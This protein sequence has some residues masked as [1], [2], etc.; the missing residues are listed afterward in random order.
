VSRPI[1]LGVVTA[2]GGSKGVPGKNIKPLG[3]KPLI[4]YTIEAAAQC[5]FI[6]DLVVSTDSADIAAIARACGGLVPFLR[7][8]ELAADATPH[9]PVL[10]HAV[11]EMELRSGRTYDYVV[12]LQPT[13]PFRLPQDIDETIALLIS[14]K[15][16][17]AVSVCE[18][19][20]AGHPVKAKRFDGRRLLPYCLDE[21]EGTRRQD[22]VPAYKRSGAVYV[23]RR[24]LLMKA[25][26]F[27]GEHVVGHI[28][29]K[30]RSV[31]IDTPLD[32]VIAEYMLAQLRRA[33]LFL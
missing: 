6:T 33:G 18:V 20:G 22:L 8:P 1:V 30:E 5:E 19:D 31:D 32:W 21:I 3:G 27:Y 10:Q 11:R 26:R 28:V 29:P 4:Q 24:E 13:S 14:S 7:P 17:S 2:R 15:A 9:L 16:D 23:S 12:T 25:N